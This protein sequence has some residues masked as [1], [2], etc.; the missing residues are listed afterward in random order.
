MLNS[1]N[2]TGGVQFKKRG[3]SSSSATS[4]SLRRIKLK[5]PFLFHRKR[6]TGSRSSFIETPEICENYKSCEGLT[7]RKLVNVLWQ[8]NKGGNFSDLSQNNVSDIESYYKTRRHRRKESVQNQ[9]NSISSHSTRNNSSAMQIQA[10]NHNSSPNASIGEKM[11]HLK[12]LNNNLITSKEIL[13][14]LIHIFGPQKTQSSTFSLLSSLYT[15]LDSARMH[16]HKLSKRT[17][18]EKEERE[19]RRKEK[20]KILLCF[21][22]LTEELET[23]K[24]SRKKAEKSNKRLGIVVREME[25]SIL[26]ASEELERERR[27][28][29]RVERVCKELVRGIGEDREEME[30]LKRETVDLQEELEREREMLQVADEWREERVQMKLMEAKCQFEEKN[31]AIDQLRDELEMFLSG[32][33][34]NQ[35]GL[36]EINGDF[37]GLNGSLYEGRNKEIDELRDELE[38]YLSAKRAQE[39]E[40]E[41]EGEFRGE[42]ENLCEEMVQFEEKNKAIDQLRVD[43]EAYLSAKNNKNGINEIEEK[44]KGENGKSQEVDSGEDSDLQS[45]ELEMENNNVQNGPCWNYEQFEGSSVNLLDKERAKI[46][47]KEL[48]RYNLVKKLRDH[49][50]AGSGFILEENK[51]GD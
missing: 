31:R 21:E 24:R 41:I 40:F 17:L 15:E 33:R 42:S 43:L 44:S 49:M 29:E 2:G 4:S 48:E 23:E 36:R 34:N 19:T 20:E 7:A 30:E 18:Q 11:N 35:E 8:M 25:R 3:L 28:R 47:E 12:H 5:R 26:E 13:K 22:S 38:A 39:G 51:D 37:E 46:Y 1:G 16:L 6:R 50:L 45:I 27:S 9:R 14:A 10:C 32:E